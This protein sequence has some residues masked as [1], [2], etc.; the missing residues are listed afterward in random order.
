MLF[1]AARLPRPGRPFSGRPWGPPQH[2][3]GLDIAVIAVDSSTQRLR[4]MRDPQRVPPDLFE[5]QGDGIDVSAYPTE[6]L[7]KMKTA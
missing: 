2:G 7:L 4:L 6:K 5:P 3:H 1:G